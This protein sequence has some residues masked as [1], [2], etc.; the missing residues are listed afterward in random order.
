MKKKFITPEITVV[1]LKGKVSICTASG[2]ESLSFNK[3]SV[4]GTTANGTNKKGES[5][6]PDGNNGSYSGWELQW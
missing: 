3:E 1:T 5:V 6:T 2:A 4:V